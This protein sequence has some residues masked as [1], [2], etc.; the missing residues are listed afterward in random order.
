MG[1][2]FEDVKAAAARIEGIAVRTPLVR[3]DELDARTG[4]KVFVKAECL[5]RGR[6]CRLRA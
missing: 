5:Q 4:A 1:P 3:N 6:Q 2:T